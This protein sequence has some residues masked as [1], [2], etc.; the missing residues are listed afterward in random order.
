MD[1]N[2]LET[3]QTE[4]AEPGLEAAKRGDEVTALREILCAWRDTE[5]F[6]AEPA[7]ALLHLSIEHGSDLISTGDELRSKLAC[8]G[9][10]EKKLRSMYDDVCLLLDGS[11]ETGLANQMAKAYMERLESDLTRAESYLRRLRKKGFD[12]DTLD[13]LEQQLKSYALRQTIE[14]ALLQELSER[15][16]RMEPFSVYADSIRIDEQ[17]T[18]AGETGL[19]RL[20]AHATGAIY[21][22]YDCSEAWER[23]DSDI[24]DK[25]EQFGKYGAA[26][27][28][29]R[30][31]KEHIEPALCLLDELEAAKT[32]ADEDESYL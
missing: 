22:Q 7:F 9:A 24:S 2:N 4:G 10:A 8:R 15:Q 14:T 30:L 12:E 29:Q 21:Y 25:A 27:A 19:L 32:E 5:V 13:L 28:K 16:Y 23:L 3:V 18:S 20:L 6:F 26:A 17:D 31:V 11:S 1:E